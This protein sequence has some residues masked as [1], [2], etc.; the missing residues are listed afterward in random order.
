MTA[1]GIKKKRA[2]RVIKNR[3]ESPYSA[4]T[5][6][7]RMLNIVDTNMPMSRKVF[8]DFFSMLWGKFYGDIG[9]LPSCLRVGCFI[10]NVFGEATI[11]H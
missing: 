5:G 6:Q 2:A 1:T 9:I 3:E 8:R 10:S 11:F 4:L 7:F